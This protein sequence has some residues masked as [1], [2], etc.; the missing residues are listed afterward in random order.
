MSE[1]S[2]LDLGYAHL[3]VDDADTDLVNNTGA[4]LKGSWDLGV[5]ILSASFTTRF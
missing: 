5:D 4:H 1:S 3:F 2:T